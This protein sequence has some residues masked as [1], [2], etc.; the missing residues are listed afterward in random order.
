MGTLKAS[1]V[2]LAL[3]FVVSCSPRDFLTRRLASDLND[4]VGRF[5]RII[6]APGSTLDRQVIR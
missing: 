4:A 1:L 5:A 6:E 3:F 2:A